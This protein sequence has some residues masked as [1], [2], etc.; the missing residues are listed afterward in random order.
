MR[1]ESRVEIMDKLDTVEKMLLDLHT[2]LERLDEI[3]STT[4]NK[5]DS[6]HEIIAYML[7]RIKNDVYYS[8]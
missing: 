1:E 3:D 8:E 5:I 2:Y 7:Y 6:Q 4:W